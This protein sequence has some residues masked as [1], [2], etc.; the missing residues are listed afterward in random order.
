MQQLGGDRGVL[1]E[2]LQ[3][4]GQCQ[5]DSGQLCLPAGSDKTQDSSSCR[6]W[7]TEA[8]SFLLTAFQKHDFQ[9]PKKGIPEL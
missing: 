9:G 1:S 2:E 5:C 4:I 8:L 6:D 7:E 3:R